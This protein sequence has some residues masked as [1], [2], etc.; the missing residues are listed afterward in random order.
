MFKTDETGELLAKLAEYDVEIA[1]LVPHVNFIKTNLT[2][3]YDLK[4]VFV[5]FS[6]QK[7]TA[8]IME[9]GV[10]SSI[11]ETSSGLNSI[12]ERVCNTFNVSP[13]VGIGLVN[14]YGF[15]FL[16]QQ[17]LNFVIDVPVYGKYMQ[18]VELPELSYCIRE[19]L[20][21]MFNEILGEVYAKI[22]NFAEF[23]IN[24]S[25][26]MSINGMSTLIDLMSNVK[27]EIICFKNLSFDNMHTTYVDILQTEKSKGLRKEI[28]AELESTNIE[29]PL[30]LL[31]R[32]NGIIS[33]KIKPLLLDQGI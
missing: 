1:G 8:T 21:E 10:L 16:P 32:I 6:A 27:S 26:S 23:N 33:N 14:K 19:S 29:V 12:V 28:K 20:K 24:F 11:I 17:Y 25:S 3:E 18:S 15:V 13:S 2:K 4:T 9:K 22:G 30:S 7:L 5:E 31:D